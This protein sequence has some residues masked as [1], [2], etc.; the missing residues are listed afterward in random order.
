MQQTKSHGSTA[1]ST[2]L[3]RWGWI[4]VRHFWTLA[5]SF[6]VTGRRWWATNQV[7]CFDH[8]GKNNG[9]KVFRSYLLVRPLRSFK[10]IWNRGPTHLDC[11]FFLHHS[12]G[13]EGVESDFWVRESNERGGKI[14]TEGGLE[15]HSKFE[16]V[17]FNDE[18]TSVRPNPQNLC[19]CLKR[20]IMRGCGCQRMFGSYH[21]AMP[22]HQ[23]PPQGFFLQPR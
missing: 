20:D 8:R 15:M 19:E 3:S 14:L 11:H 12:P 7:L 2:S 9:W 23:I 17:V 21:A 16:H 1:A 22:N 5:G 13:M 6:Y 10:S 18:S 4:Y